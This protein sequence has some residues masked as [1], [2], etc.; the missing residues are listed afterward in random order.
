MNP[1]GIFFSTLA[2]EVAPW[3]ELLHNYRRSPSTIRFSKKIELLFP[4]IVTVDALGVSR[5]FRL[6]SDLCNRFE[7]GDMA[8]SS[9][10][11][12]A[13]EELIVVIQNIAGDHGV[14]VES[15]LRLAKALNVIYPVW[16]DRKSVDRDAIP[17]DE[18]VSAFDAALSKHAPSIAA[19][20]RR[21]ISNPSPEALEVIRRGLISVEARC[22]FSSPNFFLDVLLAWLDSLSLGD[23]GDGMP[24]EII[25]EIG[26]VMEAWMSPYAVSDDFC[27]RLIH[28]IAET[29]LQSPRL[30][31]FRQR[32]D[33]VTGDEVSERTISQKFSVALQ[34]TKES[35]SLAAGSGNFEV[36]R[37]M[38]DEISDKAGKLSNPTFERVAKA[39]GAAF[40]A[41][42]K[43]EPA[44]AGMAIETLIQIVSGNM[45]SAEAETLA[46]QTIAALEGVRTNG[47]PVEVIYSDAVSAVAM[48]AI[49]IV[50]SIEEAFNERAPK[51]S[52]WDL[53]RQGFDLIAGVFSAIDK[54]VATNVAQEIARCAAAAATTNVV[55]DQFIEKV[56]AISIYLKSIET[57]HLSSDESLAK[58]E[59]TLVDH[60][61]ASMASIF[62]DEADK[63]VDEIRRLSGDLSNASLVK[64]CSALHTLKGS[65]MSVGLMT[66]GE[67]AEHAH[68]VVDDFLARNVLDKQVS[69]YLEAILPKFAAWIDSVRTTGQVFADQKEIVFS[70][71]FPDG[72]ILPS[73]SAPRPVEVDSADDAL[74]NEPAPAPETEVELEPE[75]TSEVPRQPAPSEDALQS[76]GSSSTAATTPLP[77]E[78]IVDCLDEVAVEIFVDE[79]QM[80]IPE[81]E[82]IMRS[83]T[84]A[85]RQAIHALRRH[86]H[87]LKGSARTVGAMKIG[88]ALHVIEDMIEVADDDVA[89][90]DYDLI[91][92]GL[93]D[94]FILIDHLTD[95][96]VPVAPTV[97]SPPIVVPV[98]SRSPVKPVEMPSA[99]P[100]SVKPCPV[101]VA[102]PLIPLIAE[103]SPP[104][105]VE[106]ADPV[107][108][109]PEI[110]VAVQLPVDDRAPVTPAKEKQAETVRI[111]Q[112]TLTELGNAAHSISALSSRTEE[113]SSEMGARVRELAALSQRLDALSKDLLVVGDFF[114]SSK[115]GLTEGAGADRKVH[116]SE[117][118]VSLQ[119]GLRD[120]VKVCDDISA[121]C[122]LMDDVEA[123]RAAS[124]RIIHD[125]IA[126]STMSSIKAIFP[127]LER[128]VRKAC[129]DTGKLARI[130]F[131]GAADIPIQILESLIH[132]LDHVLRNAVAHGIELPEQRRAAGK[133]VEGLITVQI[134]R[135]GDNI[136]LGITDDGGGISI[137]EVLAR[138][139]ARGMELRGSGI[140]EVSRILFTPQ[141]SMADHVSEISG[142]GVGL[143]VVRAELE[144]IGGTVSVSSQE[145]ARTCFSLSVP[146]ILFSSRVMP[147]SIGG[148]EFMIP[149]SLV[150]R[151]STIETALLPPNG[152]SMNL[153]GVEV[154]HL[155]GALLFSDVI[156]AP[157]RNR[158]V[159]VQING[160]RG[161]VALSLDSTGSWRRIITRSVGDINVP[162]VLSAAVLASGKTALIV[163]PCRMVMPESTKVVAG[164]AQILVV[165]D[166]ATIR[167]LI[168]KSLKSRGFAVDEA[169]DGLDAIE[170]IQSGFIPDL[171]T[172]DVDMPRMNGMECARVLK[173][174]AWKR[175]PIVMVTSRTSEKH[176]SLAQEIGVERYLGKPYNEDELVS[177]IN[178]MLGQ[179]A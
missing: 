160:P 8:L 37:R 66:I 107:S 99:E 101:E 144:K 64:V 3:N 51:Q 168:S 83:W 118:I 63:I 155:D 54:P 28:A 167:G 124:E 132:P 30:D 137:D 147:A 27:A 9:K 130:N 173:E 40:S 78:T 48:A 94:A 35:L 128:V 135:E 103:P 123:H 177:V 21:Q 59:V 169:R 125:E 84:A 143:D 114:V 24:L 93:D 14:S 163:N 6:V 46:N 105:S 56:A 33:M 79:A 73:I 106:V 141:F 62:I 158:S 92:D 39:L 19:A 80:L 1:T 115:P 170:K 109:V 111:P 162:G 112:A 16:W 120:V 154:T 45:G 36:T 29:K 88:H 82:L 49:E 7:H 26:I 174:G 166:S 15:T 53:A 38:I 87:T 4:A 176:R 61:D 119:E 145:G 113:I 161:L 148:Y 134:A 2:E 153:D 32:L 10:A 156:Q 178:E 18:A 57:F 25:G 175:I 43:C 91:R 129:V 95:P 179:L 165:D 71:D 98:V 151:V 85:N 140:D 60:I 100:S 70:G 69:I 41:A 72:S 152:S 86:I 117:I 55:P 50:G 171:I 67:C 126:R 133:T 12:S 104:V 142:R 164:R 146:S 96:V 108:G 139:K 22:C 149:V 122:V 121:D 11:V 102:A 127:K 116:I 58:W 76:G 136:T 13:V 90:L 23:P 81:I 20:C 34:K 157:R 77:P 89:A 42:N 52:R 131:L 159:L 44:T 110:A 17:S 74:T 5:L 65:S 75:S 150:E 138:A 97:I 31:D 172:M 47:E 68:T